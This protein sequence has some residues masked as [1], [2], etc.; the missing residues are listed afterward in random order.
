MAVRRDAS[1]IVQR[2]LGNA[3]R[4]TGTRASGREAG[5]PQT[6][7]GIETAEV[8]IGIGQSRGLQIGMD[9]GYLGSIENHDAMVFRGCS[10]AVGVGDI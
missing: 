3:W 8:A 1:G 7:A 5:L 9:G 4:K 10:D 2:G 6:E